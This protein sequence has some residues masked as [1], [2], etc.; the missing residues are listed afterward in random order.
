MKEDVISEMFLPH[1]AGHTYTERNFF[2]TGQGV[3]FYCINVDGTKCVCAAQSCPAVQFPNP[4]VC[5]K[6]R[7]EVVYFC[8]YVCVI[9]ER[10]IFR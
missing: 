1:D 9:C 6:L 8:L 10:T 5:S 7:Y 3:T 2:C 4:S